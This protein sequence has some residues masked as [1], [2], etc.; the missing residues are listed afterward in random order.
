MGPTAA[1]GIRSETNRSGQVPPK[2]WLTFSLKLD[3][4]LQRPMPQVVPG[5]PNAPPRP[6][7][8]EKRGYVEKLYFPRTSQ[9]P[10]FRC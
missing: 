5:T 2:S 6:T 8:A 4:D 9:R 7:R 3:T 1:T 10:P